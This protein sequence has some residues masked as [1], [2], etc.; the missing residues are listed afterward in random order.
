[1]IDKYAKEEFFFT[2]T[3]ACSN[4]LYS[5]LRPNRR[6]YLPIE[7]DARYEG[8]MKNLEFELNE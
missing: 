4:T 1:M 2:D 8:S 7:I 6:T 5:G 3:I